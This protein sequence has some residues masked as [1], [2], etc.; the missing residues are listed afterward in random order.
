[1]VLRPVGKTG[2][3]VSPLGLGTVKLGRTQGVKYPRPFEIPDDRA[4]GAL[5]DT[6]RSLGLNLLDTAPAY[7][8]SEER[9]G[10][11]L[12]GQRDEWIICTKAGEEFENGVSRHDFSPG[13]ITASVERSLRR[14]RTDRLDIV[15]L[16]SDGNDLDILE[17]SGALEALQRAK[18]AGK[19][20]AV[21]ASTKSPEGA[22]LAANRCD[23]VMLTLNPHSTADE[24][25]LR[26]AAS[27]GAG[28]LVK[29]ALDSGLLPQTSNP[30][31]AV[32]N[33]FRFVLARPAVTSVIVGTINPEHLRANAAAAV[34]AL[35][36]P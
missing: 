34:R 8:H 27:A 29:K 12:S 25:A 32:E 2:I 6:A 9:L 14:L 20:R 17:R 36:S 23:V 7:G 1:M 15:L 13:A 18:A 3:L 30:G 31:D 16:H 4:A 35:T 33:A 24:P 22:I 11:L 19:I 10:T 26:H 28:V 21:G 5:L